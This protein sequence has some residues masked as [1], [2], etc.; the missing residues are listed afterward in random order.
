[1][2]QLLLGS[3]W[4]IVLYATFWFLVSL[5]IKRNDFADVGRGLWY[6]VLCLY[7]F[8]VWGEGERALVMYGL[9]AIRGIRLAVTIFLKNRKKKEDFRYAQ[10][11]KDRG[12]NFYI[13]SYLQVYLLQWLLMGVIILPVMLV[14]A[15]SASELHIW[16][17]LG[18]AL[19]ILWFV[20]ESV[21]DWQLAQF[22]KDS[23]NKWKILNTGLRKYSRHPNYFGE[24]VMRWA[25]FIIGLSAVNWMYSILSPV[26]IT[27]LIL[28]V[29]WVPMLEK[30][31]DWNPEYEL[32]KQK[33]SMFFPLPP[34]KL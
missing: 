6:I 18:V 33:T 23:S 4:V 25:L 32:Y 15:S 2:E 7:Y 20:F 5:I 3:L 12:K 22:K 14:S 29:S 26:M 1:M 30:K 19:W 10:R 11:R 16:D 34:K 27:F 21:G 31:Y 17:W 28:Y 8:S 13:R 9:V 24:V